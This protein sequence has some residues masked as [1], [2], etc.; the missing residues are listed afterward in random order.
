MQADGGLVKDK[1]GVRLAPAHLAG[2]LEPLGLTAG[3]AGSGFPQGEVAQ[4]QILQH[5]KA[6]ADRFP[7]GA[8]RPGQC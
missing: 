1:D 6:L 4:A 2:E 8:E 3:Q 7:A 5:R